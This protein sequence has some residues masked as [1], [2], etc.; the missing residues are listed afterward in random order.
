MRLPPSTGDLVFAIIQSFAV[1]ATDVQFPTLTVEEKICVQ[2]LEFVISEALLKVMLSLLLFA[3]TLHFK[4]SDFRKAWLVIF[5]MATISVGLSTVTF[6]FGFSWL[7]GMSLIIAFVFGAL[8]SPTDPVEALGVLREENLLKA[9]ETKIAVKNL[10]NDVVGY[11]VFLV[12]VGIAFPSV[13]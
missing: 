9:L 11:V 6:G 8:I 13:D 10:F 7:T 2:V 3:G 12:L 5:L 4:L 1:V